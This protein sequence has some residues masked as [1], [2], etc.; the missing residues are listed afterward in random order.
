LPD[1]SVK[2]ILTGLEDTG[3]RKQ[4]PNELEGSGTMTVGRKEENF[5]TLIVWESNR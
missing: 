2:A 3:K 5:S 1:L 4:T